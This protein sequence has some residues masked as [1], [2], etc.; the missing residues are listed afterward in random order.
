M[1]LLIHKQQV[2][3]KELDALLKPRDDLVLEQNPSPAEEGLARIFHLKSGP[4]ESYS[5]RLSFESSQEGFL[6][7]EE[8]DFRLATPVFR[9]FINPLMKKALK[10][11]L[12]D[13]VAHNQQPWWAPSARLDSRSARVLSILCLLSIL[14]GY[15]GSLLSQTITFVGDDFN[16]STRGQGYVLAIIRVGVI[17]ALVLAAAADR[18]GR[19][20]MLGIVAIG[21]SL[22]T[23]TTAASV[24]IFS[25]TASQTLARSM[26]TGFG[27]LL[28]I[29]AA[30]E[31][32]AGTRA[33]AVSVLSLSAALGAGAVVWFLPITDLGESAWRFLYLVPAPFVLLIWPLLKALP[34]TARFEKTQGQLKSGVARFA[35]GS[36][37]RARL[38][39]LG[40]AAF[41]LAIFATPA[42]QFQNEF[43]RE[44]RNFSGFKISAFQLI[45]NT[46]GGLGIFL[47][48]K[49]ADLKGR[50]LVGS[51]GLIFGVSFVTMRFVTGGWPMWV[52][53]VFGAMLGAAIVPALGVYGPELFGTA[54]R[55]FSGGA[56]AVMGVAGSAVGLVAVG[57]L[58]E[59]LDS[60]GKAFALVAIAP[61]I[62]VILVLTKFPETANQELEDLNPEDA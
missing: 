38:L 33:Y 30:E 59:A 11:R 39:L 22:L 12:K 61:L 4:F 2:S 17:L 6:V 28:G 35:K 26:A 44:E 32:P 48:G 20:R 16:T 40:S 31:T 21:A 8:Y 43:L 45:T 58:A 34:E 7:K 36:K 13:G 56:L 46:P 55:G 49:L 53:G 29:V 3:S 52:W 50:R 10:N 14:G 24:D 57:Y 41:F 37:R 42:S 60:F 18:Y 62:V 19:K 9:I 15:L 47:G 5:R 25:Y 27:I 1:P 23:L 51:V 54:A